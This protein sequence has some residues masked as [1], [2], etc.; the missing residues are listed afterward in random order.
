MFLLVGQALVTSEPAIGKARD[1][2]ECSQEVEGVG[3]KGLAESL[4]T[5]FGDRLADKA[6]GDLVS[7]REA[8]D[9]GFFAGKI[10][11]EFLANA[12]FFK[13]ALSLEPFEVTASFPGTDMSFLYAEGIK[14]QVLDDFLEGRA[15]EEQMVDLV[16]KSLGQTGDQASALTLLWGG[17]GKF[18]RV[19]GS[20]RFLNFEF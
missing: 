4:W 8:V 16:T 7:S 1:A 10:K 13:K 9:T 14:A 5:E 6:D 19:E 11:G 17:R 18:W 15:V 20:S 3:C 2:V 12:A